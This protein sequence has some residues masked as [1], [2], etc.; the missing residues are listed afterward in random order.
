RRSNGERPMNF[1]RLGGAALALAW[2]AQGAAAQTSPPLK[3]L[4]D[5]AKKEGELS[6]AWGEGTLGGTTGLKTFEKQINAA[7]GTALKIT[8]TPGESMPAM[9]NKIATL[10]AANQPSVS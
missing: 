7:Y 8:F 1:L 6:L 10:L 9:G 2:L 3:E 5:A 4:I